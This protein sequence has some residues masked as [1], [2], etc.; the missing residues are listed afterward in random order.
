MS[1]WESLLKSRRI[2]SLT[3]E[4]SFSKKACWIGG[5]TVERTLWK[6]RQKRGRTKFIKIGKNIVKLEIRSGRKRSCQAEKNLRLLRS[7]GKN[8]SIKNKLHTSLGLVSS[9]LEGKK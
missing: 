6:E 5:K 7:K 4:G 9:Y 1:W 2:G 3:E 8:G